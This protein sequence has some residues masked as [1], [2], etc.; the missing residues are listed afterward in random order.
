MTHTQKQAN[1][2]A[3]TAKRA[4]YMTGKISHDDYYLWLA[5]FVGVP[6]RLIPFN[7][8]RLVASTD[9]HMN[10]LPLG[11]WD[12]RDSGVRTLAFG[13]GLVWALSDTV[14]VLKALARRRAERITGFA[15]RYGMPP[16]KVIELITLA[17][18]A[19]NANT[20]WCNGDPHADSEDRTDK[21][22]NAACWERDFDKANKQI[23][24]LIGQYGFTGLEYNG[25]SP[26]LKR[27]NE[28]VYVPFH[29][30]ED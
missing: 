22:K 5:E 2:A 15:K 28:L 26:T 11:Q 19:T 9:P 4:E 21:N 24:E 27:G 16:G 17:G 14:C 18:W 7:D 23:M 1:R 8:L 13:K 25:L 6:E 20:R 3:M 29:P 30:D 10:D 12:S